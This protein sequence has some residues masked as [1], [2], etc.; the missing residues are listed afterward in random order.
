MKSAAGLMLDP[1][2]IGG[3]E[4]SLIPLKAGGGGG[5][6][7]PCRIMEPPG[8]VI[9]T[10]GGACI[11]SAGVRK[12]FVRTQPIYNYQTEFEPNVYSRK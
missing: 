9:S 1:T 8:P 11:G 12:H 10:D 4:G 6:T 5:G 7:T 2:I 3:S